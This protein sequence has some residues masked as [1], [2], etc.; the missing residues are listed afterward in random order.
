MSVD[1]NSALFGSILSATLAPLLYV[2]FYCSNTQDCHWSEPV[3][4]T[5]TAVH[6]QCLLWCPPLTIPVHCSCLCPRSG[7]RNILHHCV[8]SAISRF[9][10]RACGQSTTSFQAAQ[11][12]T[13]SQSGDKKIMLHVCSMQYWSSK[14]CSRGKDSPKTVDQACGLGFGGSLIALYFLC[15]LVFGSV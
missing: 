14:C 11:H 10:G 2:F 12:I 6:W 15:M 1:L 7:Q 8:Y 4:L 13:S 5:Q 3:V 9:G